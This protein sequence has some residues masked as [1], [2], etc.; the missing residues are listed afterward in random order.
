MNS[1]AFGLLVA[2]A[3]QNCARLVKELELLH[4]AVDLFQTQLNFSNNV[5]G[6]DPGCVFGFFVVKNKPKSAIQDVWAKA[7]D[8]PLKRKL[9]W[10][11]DDLL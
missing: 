11:L 9:F 3:H 1:V 5:A 2:C 8:V 4:F 10:L 7:N 6:I